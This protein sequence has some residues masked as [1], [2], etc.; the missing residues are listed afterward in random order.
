MNGKMVSSLLVALAYS[1]S[2]AFAETESTCAAELKLL[3]ACAREEQG[4]LIISPFSLFELVRVILP[5]ASGNTEK[6]LQKVLPRT[7]EDDSSWIFLSRDYSSAARCHMANRV[8]ADQSVSLLPAY[9]KAVG[10]DQVQM[11]PLQN[12]PVA[13]V[14]KINEWVGSQTKNRIPSLLS[15]DMLTPGSGLILV[16]ALYLQGLWLQPFDPGNTREESFIREQG[17]PCQVNMMR[18]CIWG[19][20]MYDEGGVQAASLFLAAPKNRK[21][22]SLALIA[23]LPPKGEKLRTFIQGLSPE[24][25]GVL[26][27]HLAPDLSWDELRNQSGTGKMTDQRQMFN[28]G[29]PKCFINNPL[30]SMKKALGELGVKDAFQVGKADFS[31]MASSP[32]YVADF[33]QKSCVILNENGLSAVGSSVADMPFCDSDSQPQQASLI[34]NRPFLWLIYSPADQSIIFMGTYEG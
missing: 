19:G 27:N 33:Y 17:P 26:L 6:E 30:F 3:Q 32:L 15:A 18:G 22:S 29:L 13:S 16:N 9:V 14:K 8:F 28:L 10:R 21:L 1:F 11:L 5:G 24:K 31:R 12:D 4:S 20:R 34:F 2:S 7:Q 25:W 23:V